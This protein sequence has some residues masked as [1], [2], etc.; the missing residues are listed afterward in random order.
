MVFLFSWV[1]ATR[2]GNT[3]GFLRTSGMVLTNAV[4]FFGYAYLTVYL[5]IPRMLFKRRMLLFT[6]SFLVAGLAL[7]ELKFAFSDYIV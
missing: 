3:D 2:P 1:A 4:F 6:F 7:S 5:L